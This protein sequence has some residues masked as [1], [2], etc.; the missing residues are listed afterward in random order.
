MAIFRRD[1][2]PEPPVRPAGGAASGGAAA[3]AERPRGPSTIS[4]G[5]RIEGKV[6][7]AADLVIEGVVEGEVRLEA[8]L[9]IAPGGR[10]V[11]TIEARSVRILG[12][13]EG[14]V[15][16][17][18]RVEL[19]ATGSLTGD[20]SAAKVV[21]SEGAYFKGSVEMLGG[22]PPEGKR[23]AAAPAASAVS[24]TAPPVAPGEPTRPA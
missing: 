20:V 6:G 3:P 23:A 21:I 11:G 18:E 2:E 10:V 8:T 7:G 15:R 24:A 13:V 14:E 22:A 12:T 9:T 16:G 5:T 17:R 19:A 4:A 1:P